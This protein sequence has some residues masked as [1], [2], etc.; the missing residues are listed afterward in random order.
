MNIN[1]GV[2]T[3]VAQGSQLQTQ[4]NI[5]QANAN[6]DVKAI[7]QQLDEQNQVP[8]NAVRGSILDIVV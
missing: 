8:Q 1:T 6:Q 5:A 4:Q 7:N 2:S 3:N